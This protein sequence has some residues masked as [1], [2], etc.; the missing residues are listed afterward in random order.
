MF[1]PSFVDGGD[2]LSTTPVYSI[3]LLSVHLSHTVLVISAALL[4]SIG[5]PVR[6]QP[7]DPHTVW[8]PLVANARASNP[9]HHGIAT[10]YDATGGGACS[11]EASPDDLMVT[12]MN[13]EEYGVADYC[14]AYLSVTGPGGAV[15]VRVVDL[16]PECRAGHLDL[17]AE[18]FALI[19]DPIDGRVNITWQLVS[20]ELAGS[21]IYHF[22]EGS[23]PWWT[24][25]QVRNHRNPVAR[26]E[27]RGEGG[28]WVEVARTEYNYF[29][30]TEPGMGS[31]PYT[32]RVTD[33]YGNIL[34]DE[35]IAHVESGSV[36]GGAQFP[37]GP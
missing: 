11:F 13:A 2:W 7:S 4:F 23:N 8:L 21:I 22:K 6:A 31:G 18:A 15:T 24:A 9:I 12:A 33:V 26:L 32:F 16:C 3:T 10:F 35:G 29:V 1:T 25:V 28:E 17:S 14:G 30:Q 34:I 19:A 20:P 36:S 5:V 37:P 27:V